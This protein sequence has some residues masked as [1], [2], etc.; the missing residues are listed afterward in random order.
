MKVTESCL[1]PVQL[2]IVIDGVR[3]GTAKRVT[4][5]N[6]FSRKWCSTWLAR[7]DSPDLADYRSHFFGDHLFTKGDT[8][9]EAIHNAFEDFA[10]SN[11]LSQN[12]L[13]QLAVKL[14]KEPEPCLA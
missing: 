2:A 5:F 9:D 8:L 4:H 3:Y 7:I 1:E 14:F 13:A 11:E 10:K 6:W 12:E